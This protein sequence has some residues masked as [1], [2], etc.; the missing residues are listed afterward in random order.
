MYTIHLKKVARA[1]AT[2]REQH[3]ALVL[4]TAAVN[5]LHFMLLNHDKHFPLFYQIE[6]VL[7][8]PAFGNDL[9]MK[10][11]KNGKHKLAALFSEI[12]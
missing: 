2:Y 6:H 12:E 10:M 5:A 3:G 4:Y 8:F 1:A 11:D 7:T 9:T